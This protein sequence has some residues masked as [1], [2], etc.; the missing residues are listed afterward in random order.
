MTTLADL[1]RTINTSNLSRNQLKVAR[2]RLRRL[3]LTNRNPAE[4]GP[5]AIDA[6]Q[7]IATERTAP[8]VILVQAIADAA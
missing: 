6:M 1:I 3:G 8:P 4:H 2:A 7:D 5:Y